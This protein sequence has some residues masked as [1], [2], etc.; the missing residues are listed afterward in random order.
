MTGTNGN[1]EPGAGRRATRETRIGPGRECPA[2]GARLPL[3]TAL[4]GFLLARAAP[5]QVG[6][7]PAHSPYRDIRKG[8][9]VALS[10][11]YFAGDPGEVGIGPTDG[12]TATARYELSLGGPTLLTLGGTLAKLERVV[13]D[14]SPD[15][16][17]A[18]TGPHPTDILMFDLGLQL[19][20]TGQKSYKRLAPY[21]GAA[22]G[23]AFELSGPPDPGGFSFGTRFTVAP[24]AGIRIYPGRNL[25]FNAD[26]RLLFW[27]LSYPATYQT[28]EPPLIRPGGDTSDWTTHPWTSVGVAW[29]F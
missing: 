26:F 14:P 3:A 6:H 9:A 24:G 23:I 1:R 27:T 10:V 11:G 20:L 18:R 8:S 28:A 4:I 5:A 29:T 25:S 16:L 19:R 17:P 7:D 13:V 2:P 21:L 22:I 15:T 12:P